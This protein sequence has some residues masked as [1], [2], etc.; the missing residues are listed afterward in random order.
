MS[1][2]LLKK[3]AASLVLTVAVLGAA[4]VLLVT[5][6]RARSEVGRA[7]NALTLTQAN[8]AQERAHLFGA[9]A[10]MRATASEVQA[11]EASITQTQTSLATSIAAVSSTERGLV[12]GGFDISALN[13]C[14]GG[15]TQALDQVAVGQTAGALSSLGAVSLSCNAATTGT[16]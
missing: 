2:K 13:T 3:K 12:Y 9:Q 4:C 7:T 16:G 11:L 6:L 8:L 14:L 15:V 1:P 5:D 10:Q